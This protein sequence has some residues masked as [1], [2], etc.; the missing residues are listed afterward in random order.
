[1]A[2]VYLV[3]S[4]FE[5]IVM[6]YILW[7]LGFL[8][9]L[10][11]VVY[12]VLFT[13]SGNNFLK[14]YIQKEIQ[15]YV[16]NRVVVESFTLKTNFIDME[17]LL[18]EKSRVILNGDFSILDMKF[19]INYILALK[20]IKTQQLN[21]DGI[22]ALKGKAIGHKNAFKIDAQGEIFNA[23]TLL[24]VDV[25]QNSIQSIN[26]DTKGLHVEKVLALLNQPIY[27]K[28]FIDINA[29]LA[30]IPQM[31]LKGVGKINISFG[32]LNQKEISK[33]FGINLPPNFTYRGDIDFVVDKDQVQ[34]KSTLISNLFKLDAE[35]VI[36]EIPTKKF[37]TDYTL[38]IPSLSALEELLGVSLYGNLSV[39]GDVIL[40]KDLKINAYSKTLGGEVKA[41]MHNQTAS[42]HVK[43]I[44]VSELLKMLKQE[45]YSNGVLNSNVEVSNIKNLDFQSLTN[46]KEANIDGDVLGKL[47]EKNGVSNIP[48]TLEL[49]ANGRNKMVQISSVFDSAVALLK[50]LETNY[51]M[52]KNHLYGKYDLHVES[53]EKL[54]FI[55]GQKLYAKLDT[56]GEFQ[57]KDKKLQLQ[58]ESD[59]LD[60]KTNYKLDD[61]LFELQS[62]E[63]LVQNISKMLRY[64]DV[65][66]SYSSLN[67]AYDMNKKEGNFSLETVNGKLT[68][69]QLTNLVSAL[70]QFD[71]SQ[72]VYKTGVLKGLLQEKKLDY[73]LGLEGLNSYMKIENGQVDLAKESI[74]GK[75][76]VKIK[77]KD[78]NGEIKGSL[79]K[80]KV[81]IN[82]SEYIKHKIDKA[83][84]KNVPQEW[85]EPAKELLKLL[86]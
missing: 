68:N 29:N 51:D 58:G 34:A 52:D 85:R 11:C 3:K 6:K 67:G 84:D 80:P 10:L 35:N 26:I 20:D 71:M 53:L 40:D 32:Q 45:R 25:V 73:S 70:T 31:K 83:I 65:F 30:P 74:Y 8:A 64:P 13:N 36:Y 21:I 33:S 12:A 78:L 23:K 77:N 5:R 28:G 48:Y 66:E 54:E 7:F 81:S 82:S 79:A 38:S 76:E 4:L 55:I 24:D 14:P 59:F 22:V 17:I 63:L 75:F 41:S 69:N 44:Y 19:D 27:S 2:K 61:G 15:K 62:N 57:V 43:D 49:R 47:L 42:L 1:M 72:E 16:Q 18:D 9:L 50:V 86:G 60:A 56:A 46:I 37:Y 39:V